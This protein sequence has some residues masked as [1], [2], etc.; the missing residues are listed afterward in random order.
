MGSSTLQS[1]DFKKAKLP[2]SSVQYTVFSTPLLPPALKT[3][4]ESK[5]GAATVVKAEKSVPKVLAPGK[6]NG[7][8]I[9]K[10]TPPLKIK[11]GGKSSAAAIASMVAAEKS[12]PKVEANVEAAKMSTSSSAAEKKEKEEASDQQKP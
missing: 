10:A 8:A 9:A 5:L 7:G 4:E 11:E 3:K 1:F 12:L 6:K 2:F